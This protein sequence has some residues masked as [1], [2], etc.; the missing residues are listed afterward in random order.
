MKK[1]LVFLLF[2]I[3]SIIPLH[4]SSQVFSYT[5]QGQKV[6][7]K[8]A[9]ASAKT[10]SVIQDYYNRNISG[11]LVLPA[12][13]KDNNGNEYKLTDIGESAFNGCSS[14]TSITIPNSVISI[15]NNAFDGCYALKELI[16]EDGTKTLTLGFGI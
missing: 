13:P 6:T 1:T 16:S 2:V 4:L 5:Y 9:D 7:Y 10:C 8:V 12:N 3:A 15:G 11:T 14:L